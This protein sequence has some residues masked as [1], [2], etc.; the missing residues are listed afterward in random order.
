MNLHGSADFISTEVK[1][2]DNH[3][4]PSCFINSP[5]GKPAAIKTAAL[6][7][8]PSPERGPE[9]QEIYIL[10]GSFGE[11]GGVMETSASAV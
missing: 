8:S 5:H 1:G 7:S 10:Y 3:L 4:H 11:F 6:E 9:H 2:A